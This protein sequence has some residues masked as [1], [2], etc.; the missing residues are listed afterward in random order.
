MG[1]EIGRIGDLD[2][3]H[4]FAES[5]DSSLYTAVTEAIADHLRR[6]EEV[7]GHLMC[8]CWGATTWCMVTRAQ[9]AVQVA[10]TIVENFQT[11]S[12][13]GGVSG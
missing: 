5:V 3:L 7:T 11:L 13:S 1:S 2:R 9:D 10:L 8:C 6:S 12:D 4:F